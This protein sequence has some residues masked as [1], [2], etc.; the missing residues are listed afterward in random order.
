MSTPCG[1]PKLPRQGPCA[2]YRYM[3]AEENMQN[4]TFRAVACTH[5][6]V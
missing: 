5:L 6:S 2:S 1:L 3:E 4:A